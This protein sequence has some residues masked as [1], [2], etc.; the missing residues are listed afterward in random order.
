MDCEETDVFLQMHGLG[1]DRSRHQVKPEPM[2]KALW[3]RAPSLR[4]DSVFHRFYSTQHT[5]DLA[6]AFLGGDLETFGYEELNLFPEAEELP[7][8]E[9][10]GAG[11]ENQ[12]AELS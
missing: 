10:M 6:T 2:E 3:A 4:Q 1:I 9:P 11:A 5:A 7:G 12:N 8:P